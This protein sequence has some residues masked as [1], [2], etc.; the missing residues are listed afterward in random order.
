MQVVCKAGSNVRSICYIYYYL[1][2]VIYNTSVA[3]EWLEKWLEVITNCHWWILIIMSDE[4]CTCK[5]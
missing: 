3:I 2:G 5:A 4:R 1:L